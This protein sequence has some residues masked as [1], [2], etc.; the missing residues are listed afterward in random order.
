MSTI[1]KSK[2][3]GE[4]VKA[5]SAFHVKHRLGEVE[6]GDVILFKGASTTSREYH[7]TAHW[8]Y[9]N[10]MRVSGKTIDGDLYI[11]RVK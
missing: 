5:G 6:V 2:D 7:V 10:D 3:A 1:I 9:K 11:T 4:I 8:F